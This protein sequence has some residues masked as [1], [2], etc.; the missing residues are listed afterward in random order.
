MSKLIIGL[1]GGIGSGKSV[2]AAEF[3][4]LG[5]TVIDAD[6]IAREIVA[7]N[8]KLL[9]KI[10]AKFGKEILNADGSLN[11]KLLRSIIFKDQQARNWLE[12]LLHPIIIEKMIARADKSQSPYCVLVIPLLIETKLTDTVDRVLVIDST[13]ALQKQRVQK[14]DQ[15]SESEITAIMKSQAS[16]EQLIENADD[17][18]KNIGT[19]NELKEKTRH[20]H[21]KYLNMAK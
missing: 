15:I 3:K 13:E 18:I 12:K 14:R 11:R 2:V 9:Q 8:T 1:T 21:Q 4:R 19:I 10:S 17:V 7:P 5:V 16:R 20:L 6:E